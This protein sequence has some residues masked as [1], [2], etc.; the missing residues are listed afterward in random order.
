MYVSF[1]DL[2]KEHNRINRETLWQVLRMHDV[3][4]KLLIGTNSMYVDS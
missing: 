3:G 2:E 4:G 1:T